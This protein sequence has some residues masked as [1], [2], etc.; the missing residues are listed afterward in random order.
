MQGTSGQ[1]AG[2]DFGFGI[3]YGPALHNKYDPIKFNSMN[4]YLLTK[5]EWIDA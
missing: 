5:E 3:Y 2:R 1:V 4:P